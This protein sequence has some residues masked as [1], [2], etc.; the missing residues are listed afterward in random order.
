LLNA[1][2][3]GSNGSLSLDD[4]NE[5]TQNQTT[6][7][8]ADDDSNED[9]VRPAESPPGNETST[10]NKRQHRV[11]SVQTSSSSSSVVATDAADFQHTRFG[12]ALTHH[13]TAFITW[14]RFPDAA[15]S[16]G[17]RKVL[18]YQ[19]RYR[20]VAD[21]DYVT[22]YLTDNVAVLDQ[23]LANTRYRYQLQYVTEPPGESV[24]SQEAE[25]DTSATD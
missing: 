18:G 3:T 7:V 14:P 17:G 9:A 25:L 22:R 2:T 20:R 15:C 23:L 13:V 1:T 19:L 10:K 6:D 12:V 24:W 21:G 8:D 5:Q 16:R 11:E 4:D